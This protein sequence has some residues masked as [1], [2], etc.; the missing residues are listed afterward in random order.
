MVALTCGVNIK[1]E[2]KSEPHIYTQHNKLKEIDVDCV[3]WVL[4]RGF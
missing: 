2:S 4:L 3:G 1:A